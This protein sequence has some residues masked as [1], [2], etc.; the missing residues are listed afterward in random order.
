MSETHEKAPKK[1]ENTCVAIANICKYPDE[2]L[3][4]ICS[5]QIY[6]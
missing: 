1:L 5:I 6:F 4:Y 3:A 2:T